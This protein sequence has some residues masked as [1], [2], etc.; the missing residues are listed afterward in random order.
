MTDAPFAEI[1]RP[2]GSPEVTPVAPAQVDQH[3]RAVYLSYEAFL[4][5]RLAVLDQ[6]RPQQWGRD[7][8]SV[9][10]YRESVAPQRARLKAMLGFWAEPGARGPLKRQP[11]RTRLETPEFQARW[12]QLEVLPGLATYGIEMIPRLAVPRPGLVLQHGYGGTPEL[13]CGFT[14]EANAEDYSYRS[15]GIRAVRHG[16][17]VVAIHHPSGYGTCAEVEGCIPGHEAD[18]QTYGK[19]R[20]HRLAIMGGGTL[21]GLDML[22]TSRAVDVLLQ[23]PGILPGRVGIYGLSQG[24]QTALF[25]PALDERIQASVCSAYFNTRLLKLIGPHRA[26]CYLDSSEEDKFFSRVVS[27]FS[28]SDLVSLIAPRAFAVEAGVRDSSVDFEKSQAEFARAKVHYEKLGRAEQT[29]FIPHA[30]GHVSAT[31]RAFGFL[32]EKLSA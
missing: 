19:N 7:Y 15:L 29:E 20:L 30:E 5:Q 8:S 27:H 32:K 10:A 9:A 24:G 12:F 26:L 13:V 17:H 25:L 4:R 14:A 31:A 23:T 16:F 21:F 11:L 6:E 2:A 3:R 28:D 1:E 22:A 18:G